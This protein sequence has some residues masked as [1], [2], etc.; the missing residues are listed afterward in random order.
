MFY[1]RICVS[2]LSAVYGC[3]L[4]PSCISFAFADNISNLVTAIF[5]GRDKKT[6][7]MYSRNY[8]IYYI[9]QHFTS[10]S[11]VCVTIQA[12]N[13]SSINY[14]TIKGIIFV[15]IDTSSYCSAGCWSQLDI[16]IILENTQ[17]TGCI[18][19]ISIVYAITVTL[20]MLP[21]V[22]TSIKGT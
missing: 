13:I 9:Q 15:H 4:V 1:Y 18:V 2:V 19:H 20:C 10:Y 6:E 5:Q 22:F 12:C 17:G 21:C 14:V 8:R 16:F 11:I 3:Y 7:I